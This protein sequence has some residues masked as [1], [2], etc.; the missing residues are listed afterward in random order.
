M[1]MKL[2]MKELIERAIEEMIPIIVKPLPEMGGYQIIY[3]QPEGKIFDVISHRGS[4]GYK[5]D[6]LETMNRLFDNGDDGV[7]GYLTVDEVMERLVD[8]HN[9]VSSGKTED[10]ISKFFN[11][12]YLR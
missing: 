11:E 10:E 4:Y 8:Y 1:E 12:K 7:E 9:L 5:D 3:D 6:L 2:S